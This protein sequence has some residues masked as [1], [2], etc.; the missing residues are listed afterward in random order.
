[1]GFFYVFLTANRQQ[2]G[3]NRQSTRKCIEY[4]AIIM[5]S[6]LINGKE[7]NMM[8]INKQVL[9]LLSMVLVTTAQAT[10]GSACLFLINQPKVPK[11]LIKND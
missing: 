3:E 8:K 2:K 1:M 5:Y 9:S 4:Y 11:C 6:I 10:M 7:E